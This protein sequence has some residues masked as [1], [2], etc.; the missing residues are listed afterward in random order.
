[1]YHYVEYEIRFILVSVPFLDLNSH[2]WPPVKSLVCETLSRFLRSELGHPLGKD[3]VRIFASLYVV[4]F[5]WLQKFPCLV[6]LSVTFSITGAPPFLAISQVLVLLGWDVIIN[7]VILKI[8]VIGKIYWIFSPRVR[9]CCN[10]FIHM[11]TFNIQNGS[12]K[13]M[14]L[15]S[16]L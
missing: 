13:W 11:N 14:Q 16:L 12:M 3:A 2:I 15:L 1:M 8:I 6:P 10:H 9:H 7:L 5:P 4:S